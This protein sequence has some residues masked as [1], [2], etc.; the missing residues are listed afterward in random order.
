MTTEQDIMDS[1]RAMLAN[2]TNVS[3]TVSTRI[4][5]TNAPQNPT[6]P[7]LVMSVAS[8]VVPNYFGIDS[9]APLEFQVDVYN[10]FESAAR[11]T[12]VIGDVVFGALHRQTFTATG[13]TGCSIVCTNR[14][15]DMAMDEI[16]GGRTQQDADRQTLLF[17]AYATGTS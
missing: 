8:D 6:L 15:A 10:K 13:Y 7:M 9:L 2:N 5:D 16:V 17:K 11:A 4:Y 3:A 12:R 1:L 14:G